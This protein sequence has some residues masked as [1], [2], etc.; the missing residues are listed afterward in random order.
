M[1]DDKNLGILAHLLG[2]FSGFI[3]PLI[4]YLVLE[5]KS[6]AKEH[7]KNALNWQLSLLIYSVI[8]AILKIVLIGFILLFAIGILN[9]VF[10]IIAAVKA[11]NNEIYKY[12]LAIQ[13]LK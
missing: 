3:G 2:I 4:I 11:S 9:L 13:F 5:E 8:S 1:T 6:K 7:A 12:P 10:S